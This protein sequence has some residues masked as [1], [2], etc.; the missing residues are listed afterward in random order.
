MTERTLYMALVASALTLGAWHLQGGENDLASVMLAV[1]TCLSAV[2]MTL[3]IIGTTAKRV[4]A[5]P[6]SVSYLAAASFWVYM[7]HHPILGLIHTDLKWMLPGTSPV[8]KVGLAFGVTSRLSLATY[9]LWI[10]QTALGRLLGFDWQAPGRSVETTSSDAEPGVISIE[11]G[12]ESVR[13][14]T[15]APTRRAA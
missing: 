14:P 10:R 8:L 15:P 11:T 2:M 9:E 3:A 4:E 13:M 7:I 5:V 12:R 1:T 6:V